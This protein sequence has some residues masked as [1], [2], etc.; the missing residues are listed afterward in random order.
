MSIEHPVDLNPTETPDLPDMASHT[1][2]GSPARRRG[3]PLEMSSH[4]VL[5]AIRDRFDEGTLFRIHLSQP[6]LYARARRQ[7]GS[8]ARALAAAGVD[9]TRALAEA[10]RRS[11]DTRRR[12]RQTGAR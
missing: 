12:A 4:E 11:L 9:H 1:T 7:F 3:R 8:W 10:R 6:G 5:R 2:T